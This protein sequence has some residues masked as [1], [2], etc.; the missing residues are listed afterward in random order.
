MGRIQQVFQA[1]VPTSYTASPT[2]P[3]CGLP[4]VPGAT[5]CGRCGW[6]LARGG[7][8]LPP[9]KQRRSLLLF[10]VI[11]LLLG[12]VGVAGYFWLVK[13]QADPLRIYEHHHIQW[14]HAS[15]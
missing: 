13:S 15:P 6:T 2:C 3:R 14:K 10:Y 9:A 1:S 11:A 4:V 12:L 8:G 7:R 5:F